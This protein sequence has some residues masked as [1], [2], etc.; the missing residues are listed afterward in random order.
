MDGG[1]T[2]NGWRVHR[3]FWRVKGTVG[4][5]LGGQGIV[6]VGECSAVRCWKGCGWRRALLGRGLG[7][8]SCRALLRTMRG[9]AAAE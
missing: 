5:L 9:V 8:G 6:G 1:S 7:V 3:G 4:A 2:W